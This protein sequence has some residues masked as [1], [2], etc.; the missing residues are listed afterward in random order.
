MNRIWER[1]IVHELKRHAQPLG[2]KID[3][4]VSVALWETRKIRPDIVVTLPHGEKI[5]IDTKWKSLNRPDPSDE[6]LRQMF[7][8]TIKLIVPTVSFYIPISME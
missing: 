7:A 5:V 2:I 6:D 3:P 8:T 1:Y 4:Q